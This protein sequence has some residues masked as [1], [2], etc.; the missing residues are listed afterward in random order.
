MR[1]TGQML[2]MGIAMLVF[3]VYIGHAQITP[4]NYSLFL[5]SAKTAFIIFTA[6]CF[7]GIFASLSRGKV[8]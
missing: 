7:S 6:L 3:A 4:D 2:S 1:L 8:R 5:R